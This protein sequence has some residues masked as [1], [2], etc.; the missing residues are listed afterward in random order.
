MLR[1]ATDSEPRERGHA[2]R[3]G[4]GMLWAMTILCETRTSNHIAGPLDQ[5]FCAADPALRWSKN[6]VKQRVHITFSRTIV[7]DV[8]WLEQE[9][10][11]QPFV[12]LQGSKAASASLGQAE[13]EKEGAKVVP[14]DQAFLL[15]DSHGFPL[16]LT[17]QMA[18]ESG[19]SVDIA[20]FEAPGILGWLELW[21]WLGKYVCDQLHQLA[22]IMHNIYIYICI[23]IYTH[24]GRIIAHIIF[25]C[26]YT[27]YIHGYFFVYIYIYM[28]V[29]VWYA[30]VSVFRLDFGPVSWCQR[31]WT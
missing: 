2:W 8:G 15:Y 23:Y 30:C 6:N 1:D 28:Y 31:K 12:Q 25:Q 24:V 4:C 17:E 16:D 18:L 9:P 7:P 5:A 3:V 14:G 27:C 21:R 10:P 11:S 29:C 22:L 20:G 26:I 13:L 19:L